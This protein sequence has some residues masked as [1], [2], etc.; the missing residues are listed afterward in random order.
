MPHT[1]T[2]EGPIY[3]VLF[4]KPPYRSDSYYFQ[5]SLHSSLFLSTFR[6]MTPLSTQTAK[7][8]ISDH[9]KP[10]L[11]TNGKICVCLCA[12]TKIQ[13]CAC[14]VRLATSWFPSHIVGTRISSTLAQYFWQHSSTVKDFQWNKPLRHLSVCARPL[15]NIS[16][17]DTVARSVSPWQQSLSPC[18]QQ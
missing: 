17:L 16:V 13:M 10:M 8:Q 2:A 9:S 14:G 18:S 1:L 11:M 7:S 15:L 4:W 12:C 3:P 6:S 5:A